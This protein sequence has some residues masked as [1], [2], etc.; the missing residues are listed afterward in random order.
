MISLKEKKNGWSSASMCFSLYLIP[1]VP[2]GQV[3]PVKKN[4]HFH[5]ILTVRPKCWSF[6]YRLRTLSELHFPI[7]FYLFNCKRVCKL[8]QQCFIVKF[9]I[10]L[11]LIS[12]QLYTRKKKKRLSKSILELFSKQRLQKQI[13]K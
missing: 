6:L 13:S 1:F 11:P 4:E 10:F 3:V 12:L 8:F 2:F 9:E 7:L 5:P